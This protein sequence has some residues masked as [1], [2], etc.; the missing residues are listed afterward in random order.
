MVEIY[1]LSRSSYNGDLYNQIFEPEVVASSVR[2]RNI[3][4][5]KMR[6]VIF[7][8]FSTFPDQTLRF[9]SFRGTFS[10]CDV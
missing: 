4:M 8:T 10:S 3:E 2:D 6:R 9:Y 7:S 1:K 5:R